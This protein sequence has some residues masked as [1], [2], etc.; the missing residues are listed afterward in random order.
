M[1]HVCHFVLLKTSNC[2]KINVDVIFVH[3]NRKLALETGNPE[4]AGACLKDRLS[5]A[6][7]SAQNRK[8]GV[9]RERVSKRVCVRVECN[10]GGGAKLERG[11]HVAAET[12]ACC[13]CVC[14][15]ARINKT[16]QIGFDANCCAQ[17]GR[18]GGGW[19]GGSAVAVLAQSL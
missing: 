6:L 18:A 19:V 4:S 15:R 10:R 1:V 9:A 16:A 3:S 8:S 17:G 7:G 5:T 11:L 14:A 13:V 12:S 2:T